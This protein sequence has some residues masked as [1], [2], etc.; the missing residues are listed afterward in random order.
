MNRESLIVALNE[1]LESNETDDDFVD[2]ILSWHQREVAELREDELATSASA[3]DWYR[4]AKSLE[5]EV[6]ALKAALRAR[7][8]ENEELHAEVTLNGDEQAVLLAQINELRQETERL[9]IL[10]LHVPAKVDW[11]N[12]EIIV[13]PTFR[14]WDDWRK[15][16]V[17]GDALTEDGGVR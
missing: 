5:R 1:F 2:R 13:K 15:H 8:A 6:E 17:P 9:D 12:G 14:C 11:R 4:V 7:D 3:E 16:Y 10:T